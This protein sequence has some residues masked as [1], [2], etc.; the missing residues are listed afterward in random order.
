MNFESVVTEIAWLVKLQ[1]GREFT[2]DETCLLCHSA[3]E[4]KVGNDQQRAQASHNQQPSE[5]QCH[6][7][8]PTLEP[9]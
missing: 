4:M 5:Q 9:I 7:Q 2:T 6:P 1:A 3:M 8:E